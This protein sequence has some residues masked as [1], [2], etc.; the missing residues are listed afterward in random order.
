MTSHVREI[1]SLLQRALAQLK[2]GAAHDAEA[3]LMR[4]LALD[5]AQ[6]DALQLLGLAAKNAG[7]PAEAIGYFRRSLAA[8]EGQPHVHNNLANALNAAG[9]LP[10][11]ERHYLR[12]LELKPDYADAAL[13]LGL[14]LLGQRRWRE[15]GDRLRAG[16]G[17]APKLA[18]LHDALATA[19]RELGDE[20]GA[21]AAARRAVMLDPK[22]PIAR[23]NLGRALAAAGDLK[24]AETAYRAALALSPGAPASRAGLFH[25]LRGQGRDDAASQSLR[26]AI[27]RDP[28]DIEAHRDLGAILWESGR[29]EEALAGYAAALLERPGDAL[30]RT[31][32]AEELTRRGL[33]AEARRE[34]EQAL[35]ARPGLP[36]ALDAM[37]RL[38]TRAG[39]FE[40]AASLGRQALAGAPA[41]GVLA[42][43]LS[44]ALLRLGREG[45]AIDLLRP[46]LA[47]APADQAALSRLVLALRQAGDSAYRDYVDLDRMTAAIEVPPPEGHDRES[48]NRALADHLRG[49]H[50]AKV[51]PLEQTLEKGTQTFGNLFAI[52]RAPLV[53][54]L[55][56]QI[57]K[58]VQGF[59]E[60]LPEDSG[61][62][63]FGRK[64]QGT[65]FAGSW[66]VRLHRQGFHTNHMH[67]EGWVSSAY[68]VAVPGEAADDTAK[69]GWFKF[70][71]SNLALGPADVPERFV[72]PEPGRLVLFPSYFW[73]GT[74]PFVEGSE[75]MTVAFDAVP[76]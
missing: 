63:F 8:R 30:L 58:A 29:G 53:Q 25:V 34:V 38:A 14:L 9:E 52:D 39:D 45:E 37:A 68:Y 41:S 46:R 69:R 48:F 27:A 70:G 51:Q 11:A 50:T 54:A 2:G 36:Q 59:L 35:A 28:G 19:L 74:V 23:H 65:R 64:L 4:V 18:A 13:N 12:A 6:P 26:V 3:A 73:H 1:E 76:V 49:I 55:R 16:L 66:S 40:Q 72:R 31:A 47:A 61:H 44:D 17:H 15:A 20:Q 33:L 5:P 67:P 7:R 57:A 43:N 32:Y 42:V 24:G 10:G 75:R 62:P 21:V 56:A 71:E 22:S 60:G